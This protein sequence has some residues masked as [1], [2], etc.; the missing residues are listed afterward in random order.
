MTLQKIVLAGF[1]F[2]AGISLVYSQDTQRFNLPEEP[3][4]P[5]FPL[6]EKLWPT[7][8]GSTSVCL[9]EDDKTAAASI[10]ID[11]NI[12]EEHEW[13]IEQGQ[14]FGW[15]FTWFIIVDIMKNSTPTSGTWE[16]FKT[17][18]NTYGHNVQSHTVSHFPKGDTMNE[19]IM[20]DEYS[21]SK[22]TIEDNIHGK[23]CYTLAY[24]WG[25]GKP[26]IAQNYYIAARGVYGLPNRANQTWYLHTDAGYVTE[27]GINYLL[28]KNSSESQCWRG[29][30]STLYHRIGT[31][32]T[33]AEIEANFKAVERNFQLLKSKEQEIW[34]GLF[35]D[36]ARYGQERDTHTLTISKKKRD[37]VVFMVSDSM[38]DDIYNYPLTIK[39]C[40]GEEWGDSVFAFQNSIPISVRLV[41]RE[42]IT[43]ALLKAIPDR[44]EV[45]VT[46][47]PQDIEPQAPHLSSPEN[48]ATS[49]VLTPTLSW[50]PVEDAASYQVQLST[51]ENF[52]TIIM[53]DSNVIDTAKNCSVLNPSTPYYWR[54]RAQNRF[55]ISEWS[56]TWRFITIVP[57][58]V[59]VTLLSPANASQNLPTNLP[60]QWN[61]VSSA[62]TYHLQL[63]SDS[64]FSSTIFVDSTLTAPQQGI[65]Q[66]QES[67][68]YF[69]RVRAKNHSGVGEW[70]DV[71]SFST[72]PPLPAAPLLTSPGNGSQNIDSRPQLIWNSVPGINNYHVQTARDS[73]FSS[74]VSAD[75]TLTGCAKIVGPLT[76]GSKYY[77]RV[78]A[79]NNVGVGPWSA[80]WHFS[81]TPTSLS[82]KK[83]SLQLSP[84]FDIAAVHQRSRQ[85]NGTIDFYYAARL[86]SKIQMQMVI[87]DGL[88]NPVFHRDFIVPPTTTLSRFSSWDMRRSDTRRVGPGMYL[89]VV[90][91]KDDFNFVAVF[92]RYVTVQE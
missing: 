60:L 80:V 81:V 71:W 77:W 75:S 62:T 13:W 53:N 48:G 14:K 23:P 36:I 5:R 40:L 51:H 82:D 2:F 69:W 12:A 41:P 84:F 22:Q 20:H 92:K 58:P 64:L 30:I 67:M 74:V 89:A 85:N 88:G 3:R 79:R 61:S 70:S 50:N 65:R 29:W 86:K 10:T 1:I 9:Y 33:Q 49:V 59:K 47:N 32:N 17:L 25:N 39:V 42:G 52:S 6:T 46:R 44:G 35:E 24:P 16:D 7:E 4:N 15:H 43:F 63:S 57:P 34:V 21:L 87:F 73:L 56:E 18:T 76:G 38:R 55:G 26:E 72:I 19:S 66:L 91:V 37:S 11:D 45:V 78:R 28:N 54:V 8:F 27:D 83:Q 90:K 31:G 68:T